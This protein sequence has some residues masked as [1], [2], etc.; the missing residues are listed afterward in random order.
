MREYGDAAREVEAGG[1]HQRGH[2]ST[3]TPSMKNIST[4]ECSVATHLWFLVFISLK[5][6]SGSGEG[7]FGGEEAASQREERQICIRCNAQQKHV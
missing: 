3:G 1:A 5:M 6:F 7:V 2:A 4:R